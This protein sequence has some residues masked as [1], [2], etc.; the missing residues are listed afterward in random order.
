[1][2]VLKTSI[3]TTM[4]ADNAHLVQ[5]STMLKLVVFVMLMVKHLTLLIIDAIQY[6]AQ[7]IKSILETDVFV[8][9]ILFY[10]IMF[11]DNA[12]ATLKLNQT[13]IHAS[14]KMVSL[15][16]LPKILVLVD[17]P[18]LK[19]GATIGVF[20]F[21][22]ILYTMVPVDN[23][24]RVLNLQL[25]NQLVFALAKMRDTHLKQIFVLNVGQTPN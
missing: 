16:M 4:H 21:L 19:L 20:A 15:L 12:L 6:N 24:P 17:V 18:T 3:D 1:M 2:F 8:L 14:V 23:A 5:L 9:T 25:I 7:P 10:I 11:A 13:K 22:A